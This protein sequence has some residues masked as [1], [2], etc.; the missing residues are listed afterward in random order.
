MCLFGVNGP[1]LEIASM[2]NL[3]ETICEALKKRSRALPIVPRRCIIIF[4]RL[5]GRCVK[6]GLDQRNKRKKAE[7]MSGLPAPATRGHCTALSIDL[8]SVRSSTKRMAIGRPATAPPMPALKCSGVHRFSAESTAS[9][10]V[11]RTSSGA[12]RLE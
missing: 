10:Y 12:S 11:S 1:R 5:L 3:D 4:L 8:A 6:E 2:G 7:G 9:R